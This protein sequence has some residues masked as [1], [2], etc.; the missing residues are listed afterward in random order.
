MIGKILK[1]ILVRSYTNVCCLTFDVQ[2][3]V[4]KFINFW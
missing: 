3:D 4:K 2:N 1:K